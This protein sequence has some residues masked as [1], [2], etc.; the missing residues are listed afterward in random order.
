MKTEWKEAEH[1]AAFAA[2]LG[3]TADSVR[4]LFRLTPAVATRMGGP[5]LEPGTSCL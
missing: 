3:I 1:F 2:V 5:G 4:D